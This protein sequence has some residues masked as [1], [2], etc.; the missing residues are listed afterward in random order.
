MSSISPLAKTTKK[1][2]LNV[3]NALAALNYEAKVEFTAEG[4]NSRAMGLNKIDMVD[5][6]CP[7]HAFES[8][9]VPTSIKFG[10][11]TEEV[12]KALK[13]MG[14]SV[15]VGLTDDSKLELRSERLGYRLKLVDF[16]GND[17][18]LPK[19]NHP[20]KFTLP[21]KRL[22]TILEDTQIVGE[23]V[24]FETFNDGV[25]LSV[26]GDRGDSDELIVAEE[27]VTVEIK[28][29]ASAHYSIEHLITI[30]KAVDV[31]TIAV[32]FGQKMPIRIKLENVT[33]FLGPRVED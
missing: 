7:N 11:Q 20:V 3:F 12:V 24:K 13:R 1:T 16:T 32:E 2:L 9:D 10:A 23:I 8:Y 19:L 33:Y 25:K 29:K 28:E 21:R 27:G 18:P 26:Q 22:I 31:D 15:T 17:Y 4:L 30:L 6:L 14:D 5:I